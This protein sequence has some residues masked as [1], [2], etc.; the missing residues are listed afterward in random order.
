MA[1]GEYLLFLPSDERLAFGGNYPLAMGGLIP[2][3]E[4]THLMG[5]ILW[6]FGGMRGL[7]GWGL[8]HNAR[9]IQCSGKAN[10]P[11]T[12]GMGRRC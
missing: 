12:C 10:L 5:V 7:R 11:C 6:P 1:A 9:Q 2:I 8:G 4:I 3:E